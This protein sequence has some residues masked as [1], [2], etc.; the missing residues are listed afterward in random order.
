MNIGKPRGSSMVG[1]INV[2][3]PFPLMS[4]GERIETMILMKLVWSECR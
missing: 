4:K 2:C 1:L 3:D